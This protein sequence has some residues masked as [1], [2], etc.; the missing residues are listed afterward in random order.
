MLGLGGVIILTPV[1]SLYFG[2]PIQTAVGTSLISVIVTS[3]SASIRYMNNGITNLRLG[4]LLLVPACLGALLGGL[5]AP[6]LNVSFLSI[7]FGI[8][9]IY[10]AMSMLFSSKNQLIG[11]DQ[12]TPPNC[13]ETKK[14]W[15]NKIIQP[16]NCCYY[17]KETDCQ[18]SYE[19]KRVIFGNLFGV[20][21]G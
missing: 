19:P 11:L 6:M 13:P 18:I 14:F 9:I 7:L 20:I 12:E 10:M 16:L 2:L 1:L 17:D 8:V 15:D 5:L 3:C 21:A 4:I